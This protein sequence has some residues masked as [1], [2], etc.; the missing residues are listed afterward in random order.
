MISSYLPKASRENYRR[1]TTYLSRSD[2]SLLASIS[3]ET[4]RSKN[5]LIR[6]AVEKY[7]GRRRNSRQKRNDTNQS[8]SIFKNIRCTWDPKTGDFERS[9]E[10]GKSVPD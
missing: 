8:C 3:D 7:L 5:H 10:K 4:G 2:L 6:E 1:V 9:L